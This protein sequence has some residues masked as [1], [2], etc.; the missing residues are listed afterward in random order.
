[1]RSHIKQSHEQ[2]FTCE[3]CQQTFD[4]RWNL[5]T[6]WKGHETKKAYQCNLC[7]SEFY[8][9]WRLNQHVKGHGNVNNSKVC[10]YY[11]NGCKFRHEDSATCYFGEKCWNKLCQFKHE[12]A[13]NSEEKLNGTMETLNAS[14]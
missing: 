12:P 6:H 8:L 3:H 11:E 5:E 9:E 2:L 10:P 14:V 4:L 7:D 1:M 13:E